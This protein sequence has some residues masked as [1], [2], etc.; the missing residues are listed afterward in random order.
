MD[1]AMDGQELAGARVA[2]L[3]AGGL[4]VLGDGGHMSGIRKRRREGGVALGPLGLAGDE[5][6]EL[7]YHGGPDRAL[8]VFAS[9]HYPVL[10]ERFPQPDEPLQP[11]GFGENITSEGLLDDAVRI[12]D[13]F[14]IGGA[15]I[16]VSAPR[17]PCWKLN[18]RFGIDKFSLAV[19]EMRRTGWY[20][21]V[22][23]SGTIQAGDAMR[24]AGREATPCSIAQFWDVVQA[25]RPDLERLAELAG[26]ASLMEEWR[27]KLA[28]RVRYQRGKAQ[29]MA[30]EGDGQEA[31]E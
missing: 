10:R 1:Q 28:Q 25:K 12:G 30:Q 9:E 23:Q 14:E 18:A 31:V 16:Q 8:C 2:A 24:L 17:G 20:A 15:V 27:T 5:I 7:R 21:R 11:G 4:T 19:E 22:L 26:I 3:F 29:G 6:V 13:V